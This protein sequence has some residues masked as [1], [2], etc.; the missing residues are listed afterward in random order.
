M[1]C[2]SRVGHILERRVELR[3]KIKWKRED[4]V[5]SVEASIVLTALMLFIVFFIE[6]MQVTLAMNAV[7]HATLQTTKNLSLS[8]YRREKISGTGS[9][10]IY[11]AVNSF[12]TGVFNIQ[13]PAS[14]DI[15]P[16]DDF[17]AQL[18]S[19]IK[20]EFYI[21]ISGTESSGEEKLKK[22]GIEKISFSESKIE[23]EDL[24]VVV[25]YDIA[26]PI[27]FRGIEKVSVVKTA[28]SRLFGK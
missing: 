17:G 20:K 10:Q 28:K 14:N 3:N 22:L 27:S 15:L 25:K 7:S 26:L 23:G 19:I 1:C 24:I 8:S 11:G 13:L 5:L 18:Q 4:G 12:T 9:G 16:L 6:M 2:G 21:S